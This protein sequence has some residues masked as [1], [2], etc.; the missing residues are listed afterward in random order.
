MPITAQAKAGDRLVKNQVTPYAAASQISRR[1]GGALP[2]GAG[3]AVRASVLII[4]A[5]YSDAP[6]RGSLVKMGKN[7]DTFDMILRRPEKRKPLF[8]F[9]S[10]TC[11]RGLAIRDGMCEN[12]AE[13]W[14]WGGEPWDSHLIYIWAIDILRGWW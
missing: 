9:F 14:H 6:G 4:G 8:F 12:K 2:S 3:E 10:G 13:F 11:H 5:S 7:A 1:V